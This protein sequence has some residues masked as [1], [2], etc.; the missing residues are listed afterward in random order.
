MQIKVIRATAGKE[1]IKM[2]SK[3][4]DLILIEMNMPIIDGFTITRQ[5]KQTQPN[6][7]I[8]GISA[9]ESDNERSAE[10]GCDGFILK[11]LDK[12]ELQEE[13]QNC[14][15]THLIENY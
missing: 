2:S 9:Y 6:I 5:I 8:L 11:P 10:A 15:Q 12:F 7:P 14:F 13:I 1:A 3:N 4:F